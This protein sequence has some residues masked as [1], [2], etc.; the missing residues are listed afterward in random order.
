MFYGK[1]INIP[2]P[3]SFHGSFVFWAPDSVSKDYM[4]WVHSS[5]WNNI[6]PDSLLPQ[7]FE[8]VELMTTIDN[9]Y[10]RE[11]GTKIYLCES[12]TEEYYKTRLKE[13]KSRYR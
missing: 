13:L 1:E 7:Y 5:I 4:I 12:P 3:I 8:K 11:N 2:Q 6:N 10:F 9:K